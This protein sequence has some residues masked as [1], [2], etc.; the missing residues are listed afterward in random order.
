MITG[1]QYYSDQENYG[2]YQFYKLSDVIDSLM[3]EVQADTDSF[4]KG[5]DRFLMKKYAVAGLR[6][7]AFSG[8]G[9][10]HILEI[11][12]GTNLQ[13]ILPQNYVDYL[14]VSVIGRDCRLEVLDLNGRIHLGQAYLQDNSDKIIFDSD[15]EPI[16]VDGNNAFNK[17]HKVYEFGNRYGEYIRNDHY[18]HDYNINVDTS[19]FTRHGEFNI[20]KRRGIM[21]FSSNLAGRDIVIEYISDGI[22]EKVLDEK[23]ITFHKYYKEALEDYIYH[24]AIARKRN[25]PFNEKQRANAKYKTSKHKAVLLMANLDPQRIARVMRLG[26]KPIKT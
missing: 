12:I 17:P 15:G 14:R 8:A 9:D 24:R 21:M 10:V 6:D 7:M 22:D 5:V 3:L 23:P 26:F 25:V 2:S 19:K 11:T 13:F 20:D 1:Q 16:E 4:L 18:A